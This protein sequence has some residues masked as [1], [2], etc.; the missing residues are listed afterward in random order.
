MISRTSR[1]KGA[2]RISSSVLFWYLRISLQCAAAG[3]EAERSTAATRFVS[4]Q[5]YLSAFAPGASLRR[6]TPT[7]VGAA[8][9]EATV[10]VLR[11]TGWPHVPP[12]CPIDFLAV[13]FVRAITE[14]LRAL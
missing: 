13:C 5:A 8:L 2:R 1:W 11:A 12:V 3:Y 6:L 10:F 7:V 9:R 14:L 4:A